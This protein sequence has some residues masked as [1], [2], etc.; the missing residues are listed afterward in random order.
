M[1]ES[2]KLNVTSL[3]NLFP[4]GS[5][6][7]QEAALYLEKEDLY[8][9][10][11]SI[12]GSQEERIQP[13]YR[14]LARLH[15]LVRGRMCLSVVEFGVGFST[16]VLADA[17]Q[18][19]R[20]AWIERRQ[21][22]TIRE[23]DPFKLHS[24]DTSRHWLKETESIL[25][26]D[27]IDRVHFYHSTASIGSHNGRICHFY[28]KLPDVVPDLLYI[29][30]PDPATVQGD[31]RGQSWNNGS[32]IVMSADLLA[33]EPHLMPGALVLVDGRTLNARFLAAQ[34]YR[35]WSIERNSDTDVTVMELQE[36]PL[37]EVNRNI[38]EFQLGKNALSWPEPLN[39]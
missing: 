6:G 37:G 39:R 9:K 38:L 32:R 16:L 30:G 19:N 31:I 4:S 28:D 22:P 1:W 10:L 3:S 18:K 23:T 34:L 15:H 12:A 7:E 2:Q 36:S 13:K 8:E 26:D 35:N 20:D 14:D 5:D 29:D 24:V 33:M 21:R 11:K 27:L 17:L 25:P